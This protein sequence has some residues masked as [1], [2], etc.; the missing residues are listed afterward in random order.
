[1]LSEAAGL[2]SGYLLAQKIEDTM[3]LFFY[4]NQNVNN[5][6]FLALMAVS[7]LAGTG[8]GISWIRYKNPTVRN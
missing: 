2:G 1:V 6:F 7:A 8:L 4:T 3:K 5:D